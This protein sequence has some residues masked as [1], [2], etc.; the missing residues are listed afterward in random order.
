MRVKTLVLFL[1]SAATWTFRGCGGLASYTPYFFALDVINVPHYLE[2]ALYVC[3]YV[4]SCVAGLAGFSDV[5][6]STRK[7]L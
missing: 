6:S 2:C 5:A 7:V 1:P 3:M 4:C